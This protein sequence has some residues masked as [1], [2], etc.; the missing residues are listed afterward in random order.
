MPV[1]IPKNGTHRENR[2]ALVVDD[3]APVRRMLAELLEQAGCSCVEASDG[4]QALLL[5]EKMHPDLGVFDINLPGMSGAELAW[6]VKEREPEIPLVALSG[7]LKDWDKEDLRD[8]G[9]VRVFQK[10]MDCDAFVSFC[11]DFGSK[12]EVDGPS[13]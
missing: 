6:R 2:V 5:L 9:F 11:R 8:L 13:S 1:L 7:Y 12:P 4:E 3:E 10:P